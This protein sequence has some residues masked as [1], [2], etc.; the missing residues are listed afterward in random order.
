[1]SRF[2]SIPEAYQG[3]IA[4]YAEQNHTTEETAFANLMDFIQLKDAAFERV[5]IAV[6]DP[7]RYVT[8]PEGLSERAVRQMYMDLFGE[9]SVGATVYCYYA[10]ERL[11]VLLLEIQYDSEVPVWDVLDMFHHQIPGMDIRDDSLVL[12]YVY[13]GYGEMTEKIQDLLNWFLAEHADD[14][15]LNAGYFES[16]YDE[17]DEDS[18]EFPE[19][20]FPEDDLTEDSAEEDDESADEGEDAEDPV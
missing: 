15:H 6:E 2:T 11:D 19:D 18:E 10:P 20:E 5:L 14:G 17:D 3:V 13:D 12:L 4:Q 1:M 7:L 9:D 8:E 16:I